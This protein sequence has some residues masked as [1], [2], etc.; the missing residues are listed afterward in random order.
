MVRTAVA[1]SRRD[2][3]ATD[4][5][6]KDYAGVSTEFADRHGLHEN[7]HIRIDNGP[8]ATYY[9]IVEI[10][11]DSEPLVVHEESLNRF[12]GSDGQAV[13]VSTTIPQAESRSEAAE[14][15]GVHEVLEGDGGDTLAVIAPHA[16]GI[17]GNTGDIAELCH[18]KLRELGIDT[19]L[20]K[21]QGYRHPHQDTTSFR[22][23]HFSKIM[24]SHRS[25]PALRHIVN[26]DFD[27]VV[28]FHRSG[29]EH[30]EVGGLADRSIRDAVGEELQA[31]TGREVRTDIAELA[32]PGTAQIV[33]EN[34]LSDRANRAIHVEATPG[35]CNDEPEA[36]AEAV[37]AG[38]EAC[39]DFNPL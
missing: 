3:L 6:C 7:Q 37:V 15:G 27:Y 28:G 36:A 29:F 5:K 26:R 24:R 33:S 10:R 25:Y 13:E 21:L 2:T 9:R 38:L 8:Y 12:E 23:W 1:A 4:N 30:V 22:V 19:T 17:E 14:C 16:G 34:F 20:W 32:L 35:I 11:E 18:R 31:R 39:P